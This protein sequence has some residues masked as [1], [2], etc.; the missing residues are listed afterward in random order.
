MNRNCKATYSLAAFWCSLKTRPTVAGPISP[1]RDVACFEPPSFCCGGFA[2]DPKIS[3]CSRLF[4][5]ECKRRK[6]FGVWRGRG[7]IFR[8][9]VSRR[10]ALEPFFCFGSANVRVTIRSGLR[11]CDP[12]LITDG[13]SVAWKDTE[14][15]ETGKPWRCW[16]RLH[17]SLGFCATRAP[18]IGRRSFASLAFQ[19]Y[20]AEVTGARRA[21]GT[22][23]GG[24]S[25]TL[26][27]MTTQVP[28]KS[29]S[30]LQRV[31]CSSLSGWRQFVL[32]KQGPASMDPRRANVSNCV[33][34]L[35][36]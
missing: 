8:R 14:R 26:E 32:V 27:C 10:R 24:K 21:G 5:N 16:Q 9:L 34:P 28:G 17:G 12:M 2:R 29:R 35:A 31:T 7:G 18:R 25:W 4:K 36:G 3:G 19:I 6:R 13:S 22:G 15:A 33:K 20:R 30:T 1:T 11:I 23:A